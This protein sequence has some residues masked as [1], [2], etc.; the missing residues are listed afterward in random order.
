MQGHGRDYL[1]LGDSGSGH[2][3]CGGG[4]GKFCRIAAGLPAVT[5]IWEKRQSF[6]A[7]LRAWH[8]CCF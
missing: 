5:D 3:I 8:G 1:S 2:G 4:G 7:G 6:S